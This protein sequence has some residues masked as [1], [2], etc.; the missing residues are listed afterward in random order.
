MTVMAYLKRDIFS[1]LNPSQCYARVGQ[2][3]E[4]VSTSGNVA[5]IKAPSGLRYGFSCSV[6]DLTDA[7][8]L[9][10]AVKSGAKGEASPSGKGR[11]KAAQQKP[12]LA[13]QKSLFDQ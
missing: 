7:P 3:V 13:T 1:L 8:I 11:W 9:V 10:A 5:I 4:V 6:N 2:E 12:S